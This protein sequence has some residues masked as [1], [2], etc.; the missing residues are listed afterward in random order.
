MPPR[1]RA[2]FGVLASMSAMRRPIHVGMDTTTRDA[3]APGTAL[4]DRRPALEVHTV[5]PEVGRLLAALEHK[6]RIT[7]DHVHRTATLA[8]RVAVELSMA[9][10]AVRHVGLVG[11]L[12]DLGK[13]DVPDHIL[14][15]PGRLAAHEFSVMKRHAARGWELLM[16]LPGLASVAEGVRSHHERIDGRGYPDGLEGDEIPLSARIVSVCD[17]FDAIRHPRQYCEGV[18]VDRTLEILQEHA[19]TQFDAV[20]VE[21]LVAVVRSDSQVDVTIRR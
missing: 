2:S 18:A 9:P 14:C 21:A 4:V 11:L 7:G 8:V 5:D 20:A 6:D 17:A 12:H 10:T 1:V 16:T 19:G 15:K 13:L 3:S